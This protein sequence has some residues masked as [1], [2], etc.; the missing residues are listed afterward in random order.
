LQQLAK[1]RIFFEHY[2]GHIFIKSGK[3]VNLDELKKIAR[4]IK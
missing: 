3:N 2:G 4:K 1:D